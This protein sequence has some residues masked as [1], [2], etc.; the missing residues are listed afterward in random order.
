MAHGEQHFYSDRPTQLV[1]EALL[2]RIGEAVSRLPGDFIAAYPDI[3]WRQMKG[4]RNVVAHHS[5]GLH[6][7]LWRDARDAPMRARLR[8]TGNS[9]QHRSGVARPCSGP[10]LPE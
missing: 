8:R 9:G 4:V 2:H 7:A 5:A 6:F 10:E 3:A 1:V